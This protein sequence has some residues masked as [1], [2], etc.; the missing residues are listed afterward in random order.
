MRQPNTQSYTDDDITTLSVI[1]RWRETAANE[2]KDIGGGR[3]TA[4]ERFQ[5]ASD[6]SREWGEMPKGFYGDTTYLVDRI[7]AQ[8][9]R[10]SFEPLRAIY[11]AVAVWHGNRNAAG[12]SD[13][14]ILLKQTAMAMM[15]LQA[16]EIE[17]HSRAARK[18]LIRYS[19]DDGNGTKVIDPSIEAK[20]RLFELF[21]GLWG[22]TTHTRYREAGDLI[23]AAFRPCPP[24]PFSP[25]KIDS[26]E[27]YP[28]LEKALDVIQAAIVGPKGAQPPEEKG[29][30]IR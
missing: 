21:Y 13:Q 23:A 4:E 6:P 16:V 10:L 30:R 8:Y 18:A 27:T 11:R 9:P 7:R 19:H 3:E 15:A 5:Y 22:I 29:G 26:P 28:L 24:T 2:I 25:L 1:E 20:C 14:G 12:L 17:I